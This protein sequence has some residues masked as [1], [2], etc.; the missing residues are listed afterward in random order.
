MRVAG[1]QFQCYLKF[2]ILVVYINIS[3]LLCHLEDQTIVTVSMYLSGEK[4]VT[5]LK[6]PYL[7]LG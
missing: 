3:D 7:V 6:L 5:I 4:V 2:D 1:F